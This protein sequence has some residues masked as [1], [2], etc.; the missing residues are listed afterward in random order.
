MG[1]LRWVGSPARRDARNPS[2]P[3]DV[4]HSMDMTCKDEAPAPPLEHA[5]RR[6]YWTLPYIP[7]IDARSGCVVFV[8][9]R[10]RITEQTVRIQRGG[11]R[12]FCPVSRWVETSLAKP[13]TPRVTPLCVRP[14]LRR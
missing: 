10:A 4:S 14:C 11:A 1:L 12:G 7:E 5:R 3:S 6:H 8:V 2:S 9:S 13:I